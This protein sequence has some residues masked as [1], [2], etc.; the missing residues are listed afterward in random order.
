MRCQLR[1]LV[2]VL[3]SVM[4]VVGCSKAATSPPSSASNPVTPSPPPEPIVVSATIVGPDI[5]DLG[6]TTQFRLTARL[7]DGSIRDVTDEARWIAG[8]LVSIVGPGLVMGR[9]RGQGSFTTEYGAYGN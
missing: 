9:S 1:D 5:V 2:G 6:A 4:V 7:S 8:G 3:C